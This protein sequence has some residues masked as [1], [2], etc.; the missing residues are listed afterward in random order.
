MS[1]KTIAEEKDKLSEEV[2]E[3]VA[4][5]ETAAPETAEGEAEQ[6]ISLEEQL[7]ETRAE[8]ARNLEGWQRAQADLANARKR[9]ERQRAETYLNAK[10]DMVAKLLPVLDDFERALNSV[11]DEIAKHSW[12]EGMT[13]VKRKLEAILDGLNVTPIEAVGQPFDPN[14]HEAIMQ[15]ASDEFESGVVTKELQKGYQLGDRVIR[16][17]LVNIAE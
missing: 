14:L 2:G 11:P 5:P 8:A 13:L 15:E 9:F 7:E 12:F 6:E 4:E 17:S 16:P 1:E 10:V 3:P